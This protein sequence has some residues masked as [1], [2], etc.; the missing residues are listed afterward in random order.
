MT[1]TVTNDYST[2]VALGAERNTFRDE[3]DRFVIELNRCD[4]LAEFAITSIEE[5]DPDATAELLRDLR[6]VVHLAVG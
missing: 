1:A 4:E 6:E 2:I 3:R 5:N